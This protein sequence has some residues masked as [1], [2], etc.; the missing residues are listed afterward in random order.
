MI[1]YLDLVILLNLIFDF[2][3]LLVVNITLRRNIKIWRILLGG[4]V[5]GLSILLLFIRINS[6]ELFLFKIF[7]SILML[8]VTFGYKD[9]KYFLHNFLYLYLTSMILGGFLYFLN[10]QFSY[11]NSGM[12]FFHKGMS[13]NV[14]F[15]LIFSPIILYIYIR[16]NRKLKNNY[17]EL[18]KVKIV[19]KNNRELLLTA[20]LDSGNKLIDP[21]F[22]KPIILVDKW[23]LANKVKIRN[24]LLVPFHSLNN[25]SILECI[26][27]KSLIIDN[28]ET[29]HVLVGI[30]NSKFNLEGINCILN[31]KV[32]EELK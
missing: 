18:Y 32:L 22:G 27:V 16:S 3:L 24:T 13:I 28:K 9:I 10:I 29:N 8:L 6:L 4:M 30:S 2:L 1:I 31:P 14:I 17:N 5:G 25:N 7:I 21:Y 26:D 11:K 12:V 15:L 20:F 23:S 19:F